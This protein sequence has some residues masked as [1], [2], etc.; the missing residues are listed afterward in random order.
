MKQ[1][2]FEEYHETKYRLKDAIERLPEG[3]EIRSV[4]KNSL[5]RCECN[6]ARMIDAAMQGGVEELNHIKEMID[7][8]SS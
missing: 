8:A 6:M 3:S 7:A 2:D 5:R 4:A 1:P